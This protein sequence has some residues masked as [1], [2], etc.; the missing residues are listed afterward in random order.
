MLSVYAQSVAKTIRLGKEKGA[1]ADW[2]RSARV[3]VTL[4]TKL[5]ITPQAS[6]RPETVGRQRRDAPSAS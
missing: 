2:E 4:A 5:R 6:V 1:V 3:M